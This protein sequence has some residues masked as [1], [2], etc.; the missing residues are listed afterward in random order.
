MKKA[1]TSCRGGRLAGMRSKNAV[2][3]YAPD[4]G[5]LNV[6]G[7]MDTTLLKSGSDGYLLD[8]HA[9]YGKSFRQPIP[10]EGLK[11]ASVKT[12]DPGRILLYFEDGQVREEDGRRYSSYLCAVLNA[13]AERLAE[14]AAIF[15]RAD[16]AYNQEKY[17]EALELFLE[18]AKRD[19]VP[20]QLRGGE[21]YRDGEGAQ[22]DEEKA[23]DW[24]R[25]ASLMDDAEGYLN[26]AKIY[27]DDDSENQDLGKALQAFCASGER[28]NAEAQYYAGT[29][30]L[31]GIGVEEDYDKAFM[32]IDKA[33][34]QGDAEAMSALGY[35]RLRGLGLPVNVDRALHWFEK[36]N[37]AGS[38]GAHMMITSIRK[39][40]AESAYEKRIMHLH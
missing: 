39:A 22:Q 33:V 26:C 32:W 13:I 37:E 10:L 20:A 28:G 8:Y 9:M 27:Y 36:A 12:D 11:S 31:Y 7:L 16:Q 15:A 29:M 21:M 6:V 38:V 17:A 19:Y 2:K 5:R 23:L 35:M 40:K 25:R 4:C 18:A 30:Y 24:F 14:C 3:A 1:L 34:Y